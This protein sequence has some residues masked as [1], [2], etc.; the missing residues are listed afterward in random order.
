MWLGPPRLRSVVPDSSSMLWIE[1][2]DLPVVATR[3]RMLAPPSYA[4]RSS[5][6]NWS[7]VFFGFLTMLVKVP[8]RPELDSK[9][10]E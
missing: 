3:L 4:L 9:H 5:Y 8:P 6:N 10:I 2:Y 1:P 7:R